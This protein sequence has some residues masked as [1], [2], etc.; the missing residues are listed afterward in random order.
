[1]VVEV[2]KASTCQNKRNS[3]A[4]ISALVTNKDKLVLNSNQIVIGEHTVQP[5]PY[6]VAHYKSY[7]IGDTDI[8]ANTELY[9][10]EHDF[11]NYHKRYFVGW[12]LIRQVVELPGSYTP[13]KRV[14]YLLEVE[15]DAETIRSRLR[16]R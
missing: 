16:K 14:T 12:K 10:F 1:V 2:P 3:R 15:S 11:I 5:G 8:T 7:A 13:Y 4:E 6:R 9:N